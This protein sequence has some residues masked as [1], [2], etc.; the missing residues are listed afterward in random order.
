LARRTDFVRIGDS[1]RASSDAAA[2]SVG[3]GFRVANTLLL[4]TLIGLAFGSDW[5]ALKSM[6]P[7]AQRDE[8]FEEVLETTDVTFEDVIGADEAV[9]EVREIVQFLQNPEKFTKVGAKMPKGVLLR[10]PPGTGKTLIAKAIAGE[11]N[12]PFFSV[13]GSEFDE[14]FVGVGAGR[15]RKLFAKA[16]ERS[17]CIIFIDEIDA[18]GTLEKLSF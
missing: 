4:A 8:H 15:I 12:V 18:L 9:E 7:G 16:K 14:I 5:E 10:G 13:A 11:A 17:P 6:F 1:F 3:F 2:A